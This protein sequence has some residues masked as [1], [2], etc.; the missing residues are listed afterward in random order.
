LANFTSLATLD[1]EVEINTTVFRDVTTDINRIIGRVGIESAKGVNRA[2]SQLQAAS[3]RSAAALILTSIVALGLA[4]WAAL[5]LSRRI[6][7]PLGQF[8]QAAQRIGQGNLAEPLPLTGYTA[9]EFA[10]LAQVFNTMMA[11]LHDLISSLEQRVAERTAAA[12]EAKAVAEQ[13][14]Q[15]KSAFLSTVSHE[16]R[17]PLTSVLGFAKISQ[18]RLEKKLFPVIPTDDPKIQREIRQVKENLEIIVSEGERLTTLINNVLDLAKIEAGKVEWNM[19]PLTISTV[20]ERATA[21]TTALFERKGLA[22]VKEVPADLPQVVGD[23]DKL[24]QVVINLISNAV[25]FTEQ[26]SVTC[27]AEVVPPVIA[28]TGGEIVVSIIDTGL[29][30]APVD[31]AKV[32]E[33]FKQVG[34]TLTDRPQGTGLGLSIC[35]EIVEHHGGRIWVESELG[36]GSTFSF[37]L[38]VQRKKSENDR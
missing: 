19:E 37:T 21:A 35:K 24:I 29:G 30:I 33:K 20:I 14:N 13:A 11:Q 32:F 27:R 23:Q 2:R 26:G 1:Q 9:P 4:I 8:N 31:Q 36:Q 38:P 22:L 28:S 34:D 6:L 3:T 5:L 16:L 10:V 25:K 15:A 7:Q 17:T 12:Q 18:Q